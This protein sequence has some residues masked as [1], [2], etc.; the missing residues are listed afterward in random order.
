MTNQFAK[1]LKATTWLFCTNRTFL[2]KVILLHCFTLELF[3]KKEVINLNNT[4]FVDHNI[5]HVRNPLIP[6][7]IW[8]SIT[9]KQ[10]HTISLN[11]CQT[12]TEHDHIHNHQHKSSQSHPE[13]FRSHQNEPYSFLPSY[14]FLYFI[15]NEYVHL[16]KI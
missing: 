1:N 11:S 15:F 16:N 2:C 8:Y 10:K 3:C 13:I 7:H 5:F 9:T 12:K 6:Y 4:R 14:F